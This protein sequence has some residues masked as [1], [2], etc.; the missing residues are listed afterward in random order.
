[1]KLPLWLI[2]S[3]ILSSCGPEVTRKTNQMGLASFYGPGFDGNQ[4]ANG[5]IFDQN[6]LTA[7]HRHLAFNSIVL[8]I[9]MNTGKTVTVRINDRGPFIENRI[10]DLSIG[11]AEELGIIQA[12][13]AEVH[14]IV[15]GKAEP[16]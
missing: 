8:V 16:Q 7:A 12:G 10:I 3:L 5:E 13:V 2:A 6:A 11:A 1:V 4:T 14:I 9:D 15:I